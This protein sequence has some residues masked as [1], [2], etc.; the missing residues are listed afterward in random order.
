ML[1]GKQTEVQQM[2]IKGFNEDW[3]ENTLNSKKWSL[4]V[5]NKE[6]KNCPVFKNSNSV[7]KYTQY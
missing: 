1:F 3:H 4:L 7:D 2:T 5:N 6:R